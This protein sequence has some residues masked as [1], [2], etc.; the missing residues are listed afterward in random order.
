MKVVK[1]HLSIYL[2]NKYINLSIYLEDKERQQFLLPF[3]YH[4]AQIIIKGQFDL[5]KMLEMPEMRK[6]NTRPIIQP[7]DT[8]SSKKT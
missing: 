2:S 8:L 4:E 5:T 7:K 3:P 6:S 1:T